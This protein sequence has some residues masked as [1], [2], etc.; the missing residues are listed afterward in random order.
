MSAASPD[1]RPAGPT[2]GQGAGRARQNAIYRAGVL[3]RKPAVPT[4]AEELER[5]ARRAMSRTAWAYV[6]GGAGSGTTMRHNREAFERHR[7]VPRM[8]HGVVERDLSTTLLGV[9]HR[10]PLLVA[11]VGAADL[12]RPDSDVLIAEGARSAGVGYV[13]SNQGGSPMERTAAAMGTTPFW[14]QLY[15]SSDEALVDSLIGRAEASGAGALVVTL[16]TTVLGWRPQDLD[17][18]S[19]PFARGLGLAQYTSDPRF[20]ALVRER[21]E[22]AT[23]AA[24]RAPVTLG[25]LR[26]L[27]SISRHHPGPLLANLRSPEPRA[28]VQTFLD[29]YSNPALSWDHLATLRD[30]TSLPVLLKG[31]LHPDDARRALDLGVD[32]L[33]V[34]NHGGRQVDRSIASLDA[35]VAIRAAVG[36][37]PTLLLDSGIRSGTDLFVALALGADACLLGRPHLYGLALAGADGV[38]QV[39]ENLL[40]ELELTMALT[41]A[42]AVGGITRKLL[43][44]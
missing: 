7:I 28:A 11:P 24:G 39:L 20:A 16:D 5:R 41:G 9:R 8:L 12:L 2:R 44:P 43:Q 17:R 25:A 27:W 38:R 22:A 13:L 37:G 40:A 30:R 42:D 29:V 4:D 23:T 33:V 34:S 14:Y 6:A 18:G 21:L 32:G 1:D 35:L 36:A 3:G 10:A 31:V 19:L 26:S 15:W